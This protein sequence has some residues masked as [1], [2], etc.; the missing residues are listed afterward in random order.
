MR[1]RLKVV[2]VVLSCLLLSLLTGCSGGA[3]V[4]ITQSGASTTILAGGEAVTLTAKVT[5]GTGVD[6][7]WNFSGAGCGTFVTNGNTATYTPPAE[8]AINANCTVT[9]TATSVSN[10]SA[11]NKI[12]FTVKAVTLT[13]LNGES[14]T[15]TVTAGGAGIT[16]T[17]DITDDASG[18]ATVGWALTGAATAATHAVN[19]TA[20]KLAQQLRQATWLHGAVQPAIAPTTCGSLSTTSGTSI[21]FTPPAVGPCTATVT[22]SVSANP[23]VTKIFTITVNAAVVP[24]YTIGGTVSGLSSGTSVVLL[25]NGANALTVSSNT[26]FTFTTPLA[27]GTTYQVTVG[28]EPTGESC[29][30]A[31]GGPLTVSANVTNV[32]VT[33]AP[34]STG[35]V[36]TEHELAQ[37]GLAIAFATNVLESQL[38]DIVE[39]ATQSLPC[40]TF[41]DASGN[42]SFS[43][44]TG[45]TATVTV[46]GTPPT[47]LYPVTIYYGPN[48][49][50]A[51]TYIAAD[52]TSVDASTNSFTETATYYGVTGT[53]L[54]ILSITETVTET[55]TSPLIIGANGLG[56]F[57]V[58]TSPCSI[59]GAIPVNLGLNCQINFSQATAPCQGGVEQNFPALNGGL[60]IGAV[61]SMTLTLPSGSSTALSFMGSGTAYTGPLNS[62]TLTNPSPTSLAITGGSEYASTT[63]SGSAAE[64][65]LF[66]PTPTSW[67]LTDT[68]HNEEIVF[69]VQSGTFDT[70]IEITDTITKNSLVKATVDHSGTSTG[71]GNIT[72][73]DGSTAAIT[74]WTVAN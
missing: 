11:T 72:Y 73:S 26:T 27:S 18:T 48:C 62:L 10:T 25:D 55:S 30:I 12:V 34:V 60:A 44:N 38:I 36:E 64:L 4:T 1:L 3:G 33:C 68:T 65:D 71:S 53:T 58:G 42:Q 41:T 31:N 39:A 15:Q 14:L 29:Q 2:S 63:V 24:T 69:T 46:P 67:T 20:A 22:A 47:P 66:P 50:P 8:N 19:P 13:L 51:N 17:V 70:G 40:Y 7:T 49:V 9:I 45:A 74:A 32:A 5:A 61:T 54:G 43:Y 35:T 59:S 16:L 37:T 6:V 57:C 21:T 52:I 28:T 23:N 56:T